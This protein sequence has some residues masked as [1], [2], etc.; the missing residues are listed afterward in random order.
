M[1]IFSVNIISLFWKSV[2][3]SVMFN[4]SHTTVMSIF[5]KSNKIHQGLSL[6]L[7]T[8]I[9]V[10]GIYRYHPR[11][12]VYRYEMASRTGTRC[13]TGIPKVVQGK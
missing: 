8:G 6:G 12:T 7:H 4:G 3:L 11:G 9:P 2:S 5:S 10:R 1:R 13:R